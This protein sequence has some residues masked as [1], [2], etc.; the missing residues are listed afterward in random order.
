MMHRLQE[1]TRSSSLGENG[2]YMYV[3]HLVALEPSYEEH[4]FVH[5]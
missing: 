5:L 1:M 2:R 3:N 4:T